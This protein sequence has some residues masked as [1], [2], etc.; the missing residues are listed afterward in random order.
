MNKA[1]W[2]SVAP[3][4]PVEGEEIKFLVDMSYELTKK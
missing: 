2:V 3:E 4:S 1:Q